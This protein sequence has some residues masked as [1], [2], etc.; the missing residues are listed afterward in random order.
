MKRKE[1]GFRAFM[2]RLLFVLALAVFVCSSPA[3]AGDVGVH[4]GINLPFPG[5]YVAPPPPVYVAPPPV[6]VAPPPVVVRPAPVVVERR[7][8]VYVEPPPQV[9]EYRY[10]PPKCGKKHPKHERYYYDD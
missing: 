10:Y 9:V 6:Y 4:V 3:Q 2:I 5:V 8:V 7:R 1:G